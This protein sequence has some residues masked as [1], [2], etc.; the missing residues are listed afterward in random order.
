MCIFIV[1][2]GGDGGVVVVVVDGCF[3]VTYRKEGTLS[4]H[5]GKR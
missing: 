5:T 4:I 2:I 1:D 3:S